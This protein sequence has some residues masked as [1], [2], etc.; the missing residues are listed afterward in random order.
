MPSDIFRHIES[1]GYHKISTR[2]IYQRHTI[3]PIAIPNIARTVKNCLYV[4]QKPVASSKMISNTQLIT[5]GHLRPY[6][7]DRKPK[8]AAPSGRNIRT[9]V[10]ATDISDGFLSKV[11]AS[12]G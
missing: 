8:I 4:L 12:S 6:L 2:K 9:S 1:I 5:N 3:P 7:S 11:S 10:I